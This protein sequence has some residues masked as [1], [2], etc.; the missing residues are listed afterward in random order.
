MIC[1]AQKSL[2]TCNFLWNRY[3]IVWICTVL[4][5][6]CNRLL[7]AIWYASIYHVN[8]YRH[9]PRAQLIVVLRCFLVFIK[10]FNHYTRCTVWVWIVC[11]VSVKELMFCALH[12]EQS[13]VLAIIWAQMFIKQNGRD[14][15][16]MYMYWWV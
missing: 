15:P 3:C 6:A 9:A 13:A 4:Y 11:N 1:K 14:M 8:L 16:Y 2:F 7:F 5:L 12:L 10:S